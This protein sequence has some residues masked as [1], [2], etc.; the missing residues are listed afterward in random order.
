MGKKLV[1][2][3][4]DFS[5]NG[6]KTSFLVGTPNTNIMLAFNESATSVGTTDD[7]G[8]LELQ[9]ISAYK[10]DV[11]S[12]KRLL[13]SKNDIRRIVLGWDL[14][15]ITECTAICND[16]TVLEELD[17]SRCTCPSSINMNAIASQCFALKKVNLS[18]MKIS[19]FG[20][21]FWQCTALKEVILRNCTLPSSLSRA[22]MQS[23]SALEK[24]D[25][26]SCSTSA[27]TMFKNKLNEQSAGGSSTWNEYTTG[28]LT[29]N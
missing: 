29:K 18:N 10:L 17:M 8:Y 11:T 21:S 27:I 2:K 19:E 26:R 7:N 6:I 20:D 3:G 5:A 4:A 12:I 23:C 1:I 28:I 14:T 15:G 16:S 9:E 22:F 25:M 24:V 13:N